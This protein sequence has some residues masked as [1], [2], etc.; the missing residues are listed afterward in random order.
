MLNEDSD[1]ATIASVFKQVF[2]PVQ[3]SFAGAMS[4]RIQC[5]PSR[6]ATCG[7]PILDCSH[8][9]Q[10]PYPQKSCPKCND[11][12]LDFWMTNQP[13]FTSA[14][15]MWIENALMKWTE[16]DSPPSEKPFSASRSVD[17][18]AL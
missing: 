9:W 2:S 11:G 3:I 16:I 15:H 13:R 8:H 12:W 14:S 18:F 5:Q 1:N 10:A 7:E 17:I 6:P 4:E